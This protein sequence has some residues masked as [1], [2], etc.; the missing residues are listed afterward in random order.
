LTP[1]EVKLGPTRRAEK[2]LPGTSDDPTIPDPV[3]AALSKVAM[4]KRQVSWK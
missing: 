2:V 4:A 3:A 1:P